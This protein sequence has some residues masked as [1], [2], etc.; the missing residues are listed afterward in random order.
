VISRSGIAVSPRE[1]TGG[2]SL[3]LQFGTLASRLFRLRAAV[4]KRLFSNTTPRLTRSDS[5][6]GPEFTPVNGGVQIFADR[7]QHSGVAKSLQVGDDVW[8]H[9][10]IDAAGIAETLLFLSAHRLLY[11]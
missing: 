6:G 9:H 7:K 5:L 4:R 2:L 1:L 3:S 11:N 8:T 10:N